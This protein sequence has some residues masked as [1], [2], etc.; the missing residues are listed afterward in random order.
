M[1]F[2]TCNIFATALLCGAPLLAVTPQKPASSN[3]ADRYLNQVASDA[4]AI[5]WHASEIERLTRDPNATWQQYDQQWNEIKP[6]QEQLQN[7]IA[8]LDAMRNSLSDSQ[9][10]M[11]DKDKSAVQQIAW[12]TRQLLKF[13][14]VQ[15]AD[16]KSPEFRSYARSLASNADK[17]A[18]NAQNA[19]TTRAGA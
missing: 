19:A 17:V 7:R 3:E 12:R 18:G 10:Q 6:A 5:E 15:G 4:R 9:K 2:P 14:D 13:M 8:R 1:R 11:L 16:L